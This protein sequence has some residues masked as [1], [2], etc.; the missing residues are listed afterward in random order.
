M[1]I[2]QVSMIFLFS[3]LAILVAISGCVQNTQPGIVCNKPYI[4]HGEDCC[5]D[6]NDNSICD[7]DETQAQQPG[8]PGQPGQPGVCP[9]DCNDFDPCTRDYCT[10]ATNYECR[11]DSLASCCGNGVC[12][13]AE[14]C[15]QCRTDC[16]IC[17]TIGGLSTQNG[18]ESPEN[19]FTFRNS[20]L[21]ISA[22]GPVASIKTTVSNGKTQIKNISFSYQCWKDSTIIA[23]S[24][25]GYD[26]NDSIS[27]GGRISNVYLSTFGSFS[28]AT[29]SNII[30]NTGKNNGTKILALPPEKTA[31]FNLFVEANSTIEFKCKIRISSAGPVFNLTTDEFTVFYITDF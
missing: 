4:R 31:D 24:Q 19:Y 22:Y 3:M 28:A 16:G 17:F 5:L 10:A 25:N 6:Q 21:K 2:K 27:V 15:M 23:D 13:K 20:E 30:M 26:L 12:D 29:G 7:D 14:D 1:Y 18:K 9:E 11:H 8:E